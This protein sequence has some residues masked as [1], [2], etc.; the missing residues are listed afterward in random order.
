M[1]SHPVKMIGLSGGVLIIVASA[2][3]FRKNILFEMLMLYVIFGVVRAIVL[4]VKKTVMKTEDEPLKTGKLS[5][6]DI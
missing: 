4:W 6:I 3:V 1:K 2:L 5:S